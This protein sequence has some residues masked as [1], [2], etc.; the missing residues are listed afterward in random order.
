MSVI[1]YKF[2]VGFALVI[3]DLCTMRV[4]LNSTL[5]QYK[6]RKLSEVSRVPK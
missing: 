4:S 1:S 5:S 6:G 2:S 3:T